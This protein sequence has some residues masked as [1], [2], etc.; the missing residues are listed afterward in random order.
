ME[1]TIH[2]L[3][4][5]QNTGFAEFIDIFIQQKIN[6]KEIHRRRWGDCSQVSESEVF[7]EYLFFIKN[8]LY[9]ILFSRALGV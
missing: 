3:F 5:D 4:D 7:L 9:I 1:E 6:C 2:C 8:F